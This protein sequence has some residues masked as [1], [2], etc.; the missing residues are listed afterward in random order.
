[1]KFH[2]VF[3]DRLK[4]AEKTGLTMAYGTDSFAQVEGQTRGTMAMS[5]I[6]S[7]VEAG[8]PAKEIIKI[9]TTNA[10]RLLDVDKQ[11][12][13]IKQGMF[14]D[15]IATPENPLDNIQTLKHVAFVMKDGKVFKQQLR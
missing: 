11:R 3:I 8:V 5:Y 15:I 6:D 2:N 13:A 9:M 1:V 7:F 14:A 10:A 4:R 12:G